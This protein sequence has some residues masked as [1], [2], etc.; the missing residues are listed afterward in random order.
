MVFE[1]WNSSHMVKVKNIFC[2]WLNT[3]NVNINLK[4]DLECDPWSLVLKTNK[5]KPLHFLMLRYATLLL[6]F[7]LHVDSGAKEERK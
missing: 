4:Y 5:S 2:F 7:V 1:I 3:K 6:A